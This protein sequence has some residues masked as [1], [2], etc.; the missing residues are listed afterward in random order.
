MA[1]GAASFRPPQLVQNPSVDRGEPGIYNIVDDEPAPVREWLPF[2]AEQLGAKKPLH[3]PRFLGRLL[4][5]EIPVLQ[6]TEVRGAS[7]AKA[8]RLLD[9]HPHWST[10]R[11]MSAVASDV[12]RSSSTMASSWETKESTSSPMP[13]RRRRWIW[14]W[15]RR[16]SSTSG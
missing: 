16:S 8:Q 6:M 1:V 3:V 7:N 15:S 5:G 11:E 10:W 13:A 9:W 4:A 12:A 14:A 2:L